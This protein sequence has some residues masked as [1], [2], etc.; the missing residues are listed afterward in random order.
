LLV[1]NISEPII[2][3][4]VSNQLCLSRAEKT[5]SYTVFFA[6]IVLSYQV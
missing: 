2:Q 3:A 6:L 4:C 1:H 5:D